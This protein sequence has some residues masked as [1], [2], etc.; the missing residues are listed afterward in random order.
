LDS[1]F[2]NT[3][4]LRVESSLRTLAFSFPLLLAVDFSVMVP[5]SSVA[6]GGCF[7]ERVAERMDCP[8]V[9]LSLSK[10]LPADDV[11]AELFA[12]PADEAESVEDDGFERAEVVVGIA[13]E[14]RLWDS[15]M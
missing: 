11:D 12:M 2:L 8:N 14:S 13:G 6:G 7:L 3:L 5:K 15:G 1:I 4:G 9:V 10:G